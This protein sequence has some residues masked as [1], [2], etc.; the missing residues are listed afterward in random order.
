MLNISKKNYFFIHFFFET[1]HMLKYT[2]TDNLNRDT[3]ELIIYES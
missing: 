1:N 2:F 3:K